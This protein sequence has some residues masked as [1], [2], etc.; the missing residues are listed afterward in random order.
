VAAMTGRWLR[1]SMWSLVGVSS[2][3]AI[4]LINKPA[5]LAMQGQAAHYGKHAVVSLPGYSSNG[6]LTSPGATDLAEVRSELDDQAKAVLSG[7]RAAYLR[8][9]D[10]A[11]RWFLVSQR[12]VW[13]NTQQLHFDT[14]TYHVDGAMEPDRILHQPSLV[15]R[16]TTTYQIHGFDS[17]PIELEDGF[18]FVKRHGTWKLASTSDADASFHQDYLPAPWDGAAIAVYGDSRF[19][20]VVDRNR[21]GLAHQLVA[22]CHRAQRA[23]A[24]LLGVSN[25]TPTVIL[26][27]SHASGFKTFSG[28][29]TAAL[30]Y[31]PK[32]TDGEYNSG[33]RMVLNP[34]YVD[35]VATDPIVLTHELTHLAMQSYL[36]YLPKWL[37]EGSAEY[38]AWHGHGGVAGNLAQRRIHPHALPDRIPDSSDFY[39]DRYS[40]HYVEGQALVSFIV[41]HYGTG[42]LDE[43]LEAFTESGRAHPEVDV[44]VTSPHL[45]ASV[46]GTTDQELARAAYR[47]LT[48][49]GSGHAGGDAA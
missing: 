18:T 40:L 45:I 35:V 10:T 30:T 31:A 3:V 2:L 13:H 28:P 41:Q 21:V 16:V 39:L 37:S 17:K 23:S 47:Q 48:R 46:L 5:E 12:V 26:A 25:H 49:R 4:H 43:L 22:L 19:L 29:D 36:R 14:F 33:W 7:N 32:T 9:V 38:V 20:A 15:V 6:A 1:R 24:T 42:K 34:E 27:T 11:R 44:D 8:P